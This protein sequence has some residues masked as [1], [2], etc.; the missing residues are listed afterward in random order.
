MPV[1][2]EFYK[3]FRIFSNFESVLENILLFY[4]III[5]FFFLQREHLKIAQQYFQLVGGSA[6]ECGMYMY[7][8]SEK[9]SL[10]FAYYP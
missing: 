1:F 5:F 10:K 6:S 4:C 8:V 9:E 2:E 3:I 7:S